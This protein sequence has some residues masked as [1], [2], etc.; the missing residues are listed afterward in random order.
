VLGVSGDSDRRGGGALLSY[1]LFEN[2]YTSALIELGY[3][4]TIKR[5]EAVLNF[6][7]EARA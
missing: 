2:S 5:S 4:D 3:V 7:E 6:F 1:L